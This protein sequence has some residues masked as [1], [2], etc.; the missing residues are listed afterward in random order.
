MRRRPYDPHLV[1]ALCS[2]QIDLFHLNL[3][4]VK[5]LLNSIFFTEKF[6]F[7][8]L[9]LTHLFQIVLSFRQCLPKGTDDALQFLDIRLERFRV[10]VYDVRVAV[11]YLVKSGAFRPIVDLQEEL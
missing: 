4:D 11:F 3:D 9:E 7:H 2:R 8:G 6:P 10:R 5:K 1:S